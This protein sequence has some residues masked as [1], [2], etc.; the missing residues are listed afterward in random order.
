MA[1]WIW[2]GIAIVLGFIEA[3]AP[4]LVCIWFCLGAVVTFVAS[5]F[6]ESVWVQ[7]VVFTVASLVMLAALRPFMR[8]RVK[9]N[10]ED[11]LTN[12]D[13]YVGREVV[14]SQRIPAGNGQ[15]GRV[16]VADVSW[17]ARTVDGAEV[18]S[19]S[20]VRVKDVDSTVLVV[21]PV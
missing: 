12:A 13:S 16:L 19:G 7:I 1:P 21:E 3:T 9:G 20:R 10:P 4:A 18:P 17:L 8:K 15:T 2:L 11:A 5:F 14:V 6:V